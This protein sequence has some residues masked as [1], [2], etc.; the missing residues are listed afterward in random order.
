MPFL[1]LQNLMC[2][3]LFI[4]IIQLYIVIDVTQMLY[5]N[6]ALLVGTELRRL[7]YQSSI[8]SEEAQFKDSCV[9]QVRSVTKGF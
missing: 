2:I 7:Q 6:E 3:S 5:T 1:L 4:A 8:S 9:N